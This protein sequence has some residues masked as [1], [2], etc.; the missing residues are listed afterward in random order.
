MWHYALSRI[1]RNLHRD[2]ETDRDRRSEELLK[3]GG[4][5]KMFIF[6]GD[7]SIRGRSG[8]LHFQGAVALR[9]RG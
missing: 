9:G 5:Q 3:L 6:S 1:W 4:D 2:I 7:R 8:N